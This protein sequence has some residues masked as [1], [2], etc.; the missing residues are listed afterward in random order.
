M[1]RFAAQR[2]STIVCLREQGPENGINVV[3][4]NA[5]T[6]AIVEGLR[7][8]IVRNNRWALEALLRGLW[9]KKPHPVR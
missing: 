6:A 9:H 2:A 1:R 5:P 7:N 8:P 4:R 3:K